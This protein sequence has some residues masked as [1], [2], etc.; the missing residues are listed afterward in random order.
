MSVL[1]F[2]DANY[3]LFAEDI[4]HRWKDLGR[5]IKPELSSSNRS[6]LIYLENPFI[7]PGGRFREVYYWDSYWTILGLLESEMT[8]TTKGNLT[9]K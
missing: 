8:K 4:H 6:T 5:Q 2:Q 3:K 1:S 7:V 9:E